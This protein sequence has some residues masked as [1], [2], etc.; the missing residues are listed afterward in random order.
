MLQ[1][2]S[3][4]GEAVTLAILTREEVQKHKLQNEFY[5]PVCKEKVIVKFGNKVIPHFAHQAKSRCSIDNGGE[6]EYHERGKLH[7][8]NWLKKQGLSIQ[9][10][11]YLPEIKQRPDIL[12]QI[13]NKLIAIEFQCAR[14][15][16]EEFYHRNQG[17]KQL[18]IFPLWILGGNRFKRTGMNLLSITPNDMLFLQHPTLK[19]PLLMFFY[20]PNARQFSIANNIQLTGKRLAFA[21]IRYLDLNKVRITDLFVSVQ[22]DKQALWSFWQRQ[23]YLV[24]TRPSPHMT[25]QERKWRQWLY[26]KRSHPSL[27]PS[28]IHLPIRNQFLANSPP[29]VWQSRLCLD[30]LSPLPISGKLTLQRCNTYLKAHIQSPRFYPL[31]RTAYNPIEEYLQL[32]VKLNYFHHTDKQI[33]EKVKEIKFPTGIE[34]ALKEDAKLISFLKNI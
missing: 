2:T 14:M 30:I 8:F 3:S 26:L 31:I 6:G 19:S 25:T 4:Q 10:E 34:Q 27:L 18:N 9:L 15:S 29:W 24:R 13:N 5:C 32:L 12:L 11:A 16:A 23:K 33:Y 28:I 21:D 22:H 17:Y 7:L 1:A 20:C